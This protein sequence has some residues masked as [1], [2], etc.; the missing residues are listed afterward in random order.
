MLSTGK[1]LFPKKSL[2]YLCVGHKAVKFRPL[3]SSSNTNGDDKDSS[4]R[5]DDV[6]LQETPSRSKN[7]QS[8]KSVLK[9]PKDDLF[10]LEKGIKKSNELTSSF[11]NYMY[12]F[13]KLPPNY[14]SNQFLTIDGGL[15]KELIGIL[16][17]FEAPVR[18]A[19]GYGSGVFQQSGYGLEDKKPQIDLIFG[20]THPI[21]FHSLNMRQNPDH[22]SS[23]R[24]FGSHF[25]SKFEDLGSGI[26]FN[27]YAKINGH[28]VKYGIVSMEILLKDLATWNTFYLAG[29][30]QKPVKILKNNL[31]VQYWN[32]LNLRA[33]ATLAKH[34]TMSKNNGVFDETKFYEEIA[35][36]SYLGDVRYMLGG[37]N[38]NKVKNIVSKNLS[39]FKKYYEPIYKDVVQ[40]DS[41]YLPKGYTPENALAKL[42]KKI[43]L[44]SGIQTIKGIFTAGL[45][46][47]IQYAW[48]KKLKSLKN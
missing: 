11:T 3:S 24:Y 9:D 43:F 13:N 8:P 1:A 41:T 39:N 37:E 14:G 25:V 18:Y 7:H 33:S 10:F 48:A 36:L 45:T 19:F 34:L 46:K 22:Y 5:T 20:V 4:Q 21:H 47:S 35:G 32:Q 17:N 40:N 26:Y 15:Q 42:Q 44:N 28:D 23:M 16:N 6:I 38:P 30:L 12:K 29:R 31:T 27:P 2:R